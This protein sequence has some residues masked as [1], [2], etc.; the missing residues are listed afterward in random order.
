MPL[1]P[2][3]SRQTPQ[4]HSPLPLHQLLRLKASRN[5]RDRRRLAL[6]EG[7]GSLIAAVDQNTPIHTLVVS[8]TLL[9]AGQAR[10]V[11]R[12]L[13]HTGTPTLELSP[14]DFRRFS[15]TPRAS[16]VG[17]VFRQHVERLRSVDP[18]RDLAWLVI[19]RMRSPGNLGGLLRSSAAA[20]GAG[21][22]LMDRDTDPYDPGAIRGAMGAIHKQRIVGTTAHELGA[23]I[24]DRGLNC[25]VG[26]SGEATRSY[27]DYPFRPG[28]LLVLGEE[29]KGLDAKQRALCQDL[30]H[31]PMEPG[32]D[33]LNVSVAG[34]LLLYEVRR[35]AESL[36]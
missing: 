17:L 3:P 13:R 9:T 29:R 31:I 25:V 33:S 10:R 28:T 23:W 2:E 12:D 20:G 26:A 30:V 15:M 18:D 21:V 32:C 14:E 22:I 8:P 27:L 6:C 36:P 16:G 11:A 34:A 24:E 19:G 7:V 1:E 35:R 4:P 5:F